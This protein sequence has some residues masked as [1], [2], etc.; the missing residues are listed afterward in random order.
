MNV[1]RYIRRHQLAH[2]LSELISAPF[3]QKK[4]LGI[5][6]CTMYMYTFVH[7]YII[8]TKKNHS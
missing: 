5:Q 6:V 7:T 4:E 8:K 2:L 1:Y 3:G